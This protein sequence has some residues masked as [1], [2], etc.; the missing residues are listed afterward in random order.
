M[1]VGIP[2]LYVVEIGMIFVCKK[3][4]VSMSVKDIYNEWY[5]ACNEGMDCIS[6]LK[7]MIDVREG[8][9]SCHVFNID[10]VLHIITDI[11]TN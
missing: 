10:H 4:Y 5:E 1:L 2:S 8:R 11:G 7:E 6:V 9:G 3:G